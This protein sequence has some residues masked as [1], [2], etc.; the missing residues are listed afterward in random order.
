MEKGALR[1][2]VLWIVREKGPCTAMDVCSTLRLER[3]ISLTAVQTVLNRLVEQKL[4]TR[5]GT[6]RHYRY[7][8][9]PTDE[10]IKARASKAA[11]D[12][13][14]Q[15]GELGLAHFLDTMDELLPDS[16]Q[17]LERLLAERRKMRK[18]E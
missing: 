17:Q 5:S 1:Q 15:S 6:R 16:I 10:V 12:L 11:S 3:D 2:Q 9:Q 14:S 8:A 18:E 7:E 13:L 4:L